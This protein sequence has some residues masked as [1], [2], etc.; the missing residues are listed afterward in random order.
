MQALLV[1]LDVP[2]VKG[3]AFC[4]DDLGNIHHEDGGPRMAHIT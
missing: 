2:L 4:L 3:W 1:G